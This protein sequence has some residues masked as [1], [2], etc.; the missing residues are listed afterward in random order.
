MTR[1]RG[2]LAAII[3]TSVLVGFFVATG[4]SKWRGE[5]PREAPAGHPPV[6]QQPPKT[7]SQTEEKKR[8]V[9]GSRSDPVELDQLQALGYIEG[10][11]DPELKNSGV[12]LNR[13]DLSYNG[14]N[15][16]YS[17]KSNVA[18]LI[19]MDGKEI[20]RWSQEGY[21]GHAHLLPDGSLIATTKE[22]RI[23]KLDKRSRMVWQ[24][25]RR[26]HHDFDVT[27]DGR[28]YALIR[29]PRQVPAL[30]PEIP[31]LDDGILILDRD[32][33]PI[34]EFSILRT[35]LNSPYRFLRRYVSHLKGDKSKGDLDILHVN[36]V[37]VFDGRLSSFGPLYKKGNI[38]IG[39]RNNHSIAVIDGD[40]HQTAWLWGPSNLGF[41]HHPTL[42][43]NGNLLIFNNGTPQR[44]QSK[45]LELDP[46]TDQIVWLYTKDDFFSEFRGSNQRLPNGNTLITE[47][48]TGYVF[49]VTKGGEEVWRFANP[50]I[51]GGVRAPIWRMVRFARDQ[52][53]F[54]KTQ[55][56]M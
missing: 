55:G 41:P 19:D 18:L 32:G 20:H 30:H 31:V 42:L 36:H 50:D 11:P 23:F 15:F 46:R 56:P 33:N 12:V 45:I 4:I 13:K 44:K 14:V 22:E 39:I 54:L 34:E 43:E 25:E 10:V 49:E 38:L 21:F 16:Y 2:Q 5:P 51:D 40:T 47:S 37:E 35:F 3:F 1:S 6:V 17:A 24:H 9:I 48:D 28:I 53:P 52:L 8:V 27:P 7:S 26:V 29:E